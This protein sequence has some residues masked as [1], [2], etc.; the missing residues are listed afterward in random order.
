MA[1]KMRPVDNRVKQY[2]FDIE[3]SIA[4]VQLFMAAVGSFEEYE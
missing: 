4:D 1:Q 3:Q 2:L